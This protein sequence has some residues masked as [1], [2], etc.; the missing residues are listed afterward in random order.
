MNWILSIPLRLGYVPVINRGQQDI[1]RHKAI[2]VALE[3]E[4]NFFESHEAYASK[5]AYCGTPYL[6]KR[7]NLVRIG[8]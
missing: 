2:S 1:D 3:A 4:R 5:A 6:A 8:A 7:L